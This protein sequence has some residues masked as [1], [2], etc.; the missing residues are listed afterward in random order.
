MS[1]KCLMT[2]FCYTVVLLDAQ[3]SKTNQH[4]RYFYNYFNT[5]WSVDLF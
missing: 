3:L 1:N 5:L 4:G 2:L